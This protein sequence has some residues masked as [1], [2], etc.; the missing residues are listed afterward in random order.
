MKFPNGNRT[1]EKSEIKF[2][3]GNRA[4]EKSEIKSPNGNRTSEMSEI[5]FPNGNRAKGIR[6]SNERKDDES[7]SN[8]YSTSDIYLRKSV[9][10]E[11]NSYAADQTK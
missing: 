1:S 6:L 3:N 8:T 5:K 7:N 2:P 9:S 10:S 11:I 4:S